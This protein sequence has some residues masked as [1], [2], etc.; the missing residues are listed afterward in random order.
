MTTWDDIEDQSYLDSISVTVVEADHVDGEKLNWRLTVK[1][2]VGHQFELE[3]WQKHDPLTDW[4]EGA[5]YEIRNGYGQTWSNGGEKKLHSS[6]KWTANRV[7]D[8]HD[9]RLLVMGD[10]HI[11]R[12]EHPS[13]PYQSID[14]AGRFREAIEVAIAHE[15]DCILHTG[16]VF[17]D[18]VTD[19]ECG[20]VDA[21]FQRLSDAN[22]H[23]Y[24]ILGNH[25]CAQGNQLLQRWEQRGVA[26]HLDMTGT[27]L[28]GGGSLYGYDHRKG[29]EFS[30][31]EMDVPSVPMKSP[32]I[33]VVHQTLAPFRAGADVDLNEINSQ[34]LGGF[35]YVVSGHLHDP[36]RPDWS[37]GEF[38]YAG[39]TEDIST[40]TSPSDPSV[41]ILTIEGGSIETTRR[42]L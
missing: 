27:D 22:I 11:G 8:A 19:E 16:D 31:E 40:N 37:D 18:Y 21:A 36:E 20:T 30:V 5:E 25:E 34:S 33:L 10:S 38:L 7:G 6:R 28:M 9:C 39:S 3:I 35:D 42:K 14:C 1:D 17:H 13:K 41:W 24:Y 26:T 23:F 32:S 2:P 4:E 12:D 29:S 15:V